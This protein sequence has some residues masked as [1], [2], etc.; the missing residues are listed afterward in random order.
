MVLMPA[1]QNF[2]DGIDPPYGVPVTIVG[3]DGPQHIHIGP[4]D[5]NYVINVGGSSDYIYDFQID[6]YLTYS[7]DMGSGNDEIEIET[8]NGIYLNSNLD[9]FSLLEGGDGVDW[10]N[11]R[12]ANPDSLYDPETGL[13]TELTLS[14]AGATGFENLRGTDGND[15]IT[16]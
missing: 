2:D 3:N 7:V 4:D 1:H 5:F 10:L 16:W 11:F 14:T 12:D 13:K 15:V 6:H 9:A 8:A